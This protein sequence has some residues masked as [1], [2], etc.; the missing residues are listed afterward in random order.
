M[1][2]KKD[3]LLRKLKYCRAEILYLF[4][5][6]KDKNIK[7]ILKEQIAAK[8]LDRKYVRKYFSLVECNEK[9][10]NAQVPHVCWVYWEQGKE[11]MPSIAKTCFNS[12]KRLFEKNGW[13]VILL[14][15]E[16]AKEKTDIPA[17]IWE[18]YYK[19]KIGKA[20]MSDIIR[21]S[22]LDL[23][24]GIWIDATVFFSENNSIPL[25]LYDAPFFA[26]SNLERNDKYI[27][28]SSWLLSSSKSNPL[29]KHTKN[30][31]YK[32]WEKENVTIQ[33]YLFHLIFKL[34]TDHEPVLWQNVAKYS[35]LPPHILQKELW[36]KYDEKR[37]NQIYAMS[38]VHKLIWR[39]PK[40][41]GK[42]SIYMRLIINEKEISE[43]C[44]ILQEPNKTG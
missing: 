20:H 37:L 15:I 31:L 17:Y 21:A 40:E 33:Y 30:I 1:V 28:I 27:N 29:I 4:F 42:D 16:Q 18:K 14:N 32:Y 12:V 13:R 38:P 6:D 35:N 3:E 26:F 41:I 25:F 24:G 19:G 7:N 9:E 39:V 10:I 8:Y 11:N 44:S 22:L 5:T 2:N 36:M 34:V 23:Y 43:S